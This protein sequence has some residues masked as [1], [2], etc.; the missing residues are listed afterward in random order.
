[1]ARSS[2]PISSII[3]VISEHIFGFCCISK[4]RK[5]YIYRPTSFSY[6]RAFKGGK[7]EGERGEIKMKVKESETSGENYSKI[8][9]G[10]HLSRRTF[11]KLV[12]FA[13]AMALLGVQNV[14]AFL[15][16][17]GKLLGNPEPKEINLIWLEGQDCAGD[18]ISIKQ[19]SNPTLIDIV[20]GAV[21]GLG[22]LKLVF[23][24]TLMPTWGDDAAK[25]LVD[26]MAGKYD[27]FVLIL[28]GAIP[29][30]S[31]SGEGVFCVIGEYEDRVLTL[32]EV[33]DGLAAR[34]AAAVAVGTCASYGG[35]PSGAPNPTGS[36]GL[37]D[38]LGKGW[39]G[40]LGLP[41]VCIPGCPPRPDNMVQTMGQA[42]LAVRGLAPLPELDEWHRPVS[43]YGY[44]AHEMCP[45]ADFYAK[46]QDAHAFGEMG[47][48]AAIGC[49]GIISYCNAS[50]QWMDGYGGCTR[51]GS[52]CI[53]C[54][55]PEFPDPPTSP[56]FAKPPMGPFVSETMSGMWG[57]MKMGFARLTRRKI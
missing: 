43:L 35:I 22:G 41:V 13:S 19:A 14:S 47:C 53:G 8:Y 30:E 26:A 40:G 12:A 39:K 32:T 7:K 6:G 5:A 9:S 29:D 1:V 34:C 10:I 28:E 57:H 4:K 56:F 20:T 23:H 16:E 31:K 38:Y 46:G 25:V 37:L 3:V 18:T 45:I 42:V 52:P 15:E 51:T 21:P 55:L 17:L 48:L 54:A 49:K 24:P 33:I 27:P 2:L 11:T 36:K 50:T 44:T